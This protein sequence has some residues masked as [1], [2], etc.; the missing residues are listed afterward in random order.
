LS[1]NN[2]RVKAV[3]FDL[4][5][6]LLF[7][8]NG[9]SIQRS[10]ARCKNLA[11]ALNNFGIK[12]SKEHVAQALDETVSSLVKIWE[13][14]RDVSH[15]EQLKLIIKCLT[16]GALTLNDECISELSYA[17]TSPIFEIPPYINPDAPNVL[18]WLKDQ[19]KQTAIICNTGLTP[20]F[21]LRNFLEKNG[22][23]KY[24]DLM[25]FSD[26]IGFRKPHPKIFEIAAEKLNAEPCEI[27]HVGDNLKTD[28]M[29]AKNAGFKAVHFVCDVGR[30]R[31][32]EADPKSLVH[33]SRKLDGLCETG[34][35]P[36]RAISSLSALIE[37][38]KLL[39]WQ[40]P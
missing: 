30:D 28:V 27:I 6:T 29:G 19:N 9:Y 14:N 25:L 37:V 15:I 34:I 22:I 24:F 7:E 21:A 38:I 13:T 17:Y 8:K 11:Q 32:A 33:I 20:G 26:E 10:D 12:I 16:K 3:T 31:I 5:E 40:T 39:E 23:A 18:K 4:W 2:L 35:I 1:V 36:D